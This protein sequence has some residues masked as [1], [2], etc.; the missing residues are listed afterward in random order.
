MGE[1]EFVYF[2]A[3]VHGGKINKLLE[4]VDVGG[5]KLEVGLYNYRQK[6]VHSSFRL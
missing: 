6:E 1:R 2:V 3:E 4:E 5:W